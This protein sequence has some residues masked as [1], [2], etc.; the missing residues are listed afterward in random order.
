MYFAAN[1]NSPRPMV[2]GC[3]CVRTNSLV[4]RGDVDGYVAQG[5][6]TAGVDEAEFLVGETAA[7]YR[8]GNV[9]L[10]R[11]ELRVAPTASA[12]TAVGGRIESGSFHGA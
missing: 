8:S 5:E 11:E 6:G 12:A 3:L 10:T 1:K 2:S 7:V 4:R 9:D